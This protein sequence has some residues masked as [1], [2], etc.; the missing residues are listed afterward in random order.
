MSKLSDS[1][2]LS[3]VG[4]SPSRHITSRWRADTEYGPGQ[5][6]D[7]VEVS[8]KFCARS[9]VSDAQKR[10]MNFDYDS[11]VRKMLGEQIVWAVFGEFMDPIQDI[12][13]L[14]YE[15]KREEAIDAVH[16]LKDRMFNL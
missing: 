6:N 9:V 4:V 2:K 16:N 11:S 15:D 1:L 14:L 3:Q 5:Y 13:R 10:S 12:L 7:V 8:T